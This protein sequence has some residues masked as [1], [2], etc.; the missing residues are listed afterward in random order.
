MI[1]SGSSS[2]GR[3]LLIASL[4]QDTKREAESNLQS[5]RAEARNLVE[6]ATVQ[7]ERKRELACEK[8]REEAP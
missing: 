7:R 5:A 2:S 1:Y 8:A 6:N 3:D 4:W